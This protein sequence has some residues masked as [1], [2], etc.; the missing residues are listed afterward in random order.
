MVS[1]KAMY[2]LAVGVVALGL[3][4]KYQ[5]GEFR[6]AHRLADCAVLSAE[7]AAQR[8]LAVV[9]MAEVMLGRNPA[10]VA[11]L[12]G[13]LARLE[14]RSENLPSADVQQDLARAQHD[15]EQMN[16]ELQGMNTAVRVNVPCP[17]VRHMSHRFTAM[18][19][20][21]MTDGEL[22]VNGTT[23]DLRGLE[24]L[25]SL[26]SL[27][28][29]ETLQDLQPIQSMQSLESLRSLQSLGS[30]RERRSWNHVPGGRLTIKVRKMHTDDGTI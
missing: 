18:T 6:C 8:G 30:M 14:A 16:V 25:Q 21:Q 28:S 29:L 9:S 12:Q 23:V 11:R 4:S 27:R 15:L 5:Q 1:D 19:V 22:V 10:D 24:S 26:E 20:P 2:W 7:H 3:N 17:E 13:T